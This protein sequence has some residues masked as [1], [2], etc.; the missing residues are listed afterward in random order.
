M[1]VDAAPDLDIVEE[2]TIKLRV[3]SPARM[4]QIPNGD[5]DMHG[6]ALSSVRAFLLPG[7]KVEVI[8]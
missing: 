6:V 7:R 1:S 4:G 3:T 5:A 8:D 2:F